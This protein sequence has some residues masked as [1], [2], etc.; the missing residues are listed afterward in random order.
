MLWFV[1]SF[2]SILFAF[3]G[4][5]Y[6]P[7]AKSPKRKFIFRVLLVLTLSYIT[8]LGGNIAEAPDHDAYLWHFNDYAQNGLSSVLDSFR[9]SIFDV[10]GEGFEPLFALLNVLGSKI[11]LSAVG[12]CLMVAIITNA[13]FVSVIFRFRLP[14]LSVILFLVSIDYFQEVNIV[15]QMLAVSICIFSLKYFEEKKWILF[16]VLVIAASFI[17]TSASIMLFLLIFVPLLSEKRR[18]A[19]L[20]L[21]FFLWV[22]SLMVSFGLIPINIGI[23]SAFSYYEQYMNG[24]REGAVFDIIYNFVVIAFLFFAFTEKKKNDLT[25]YAILFILGCVLRNFA[26]QYYWFYRVSFYFSFVYCCFVP[27]FF[28]K[29]GRLNSHG[30]KTQISLPLVFIALYYCLILVRGY[31]LHEPSNTLGTVMYSISEII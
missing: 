28:L 11:G 30:S 18:D 22:F 3:L 29:H 7:M 21:L 31:I 13:L 26:V 5:D 9:Q 10:R 12:F 6:G 15:R 1:V 14:Y 19:L 8:G 25:I 20:L 23:L 16:G 24:L 17:H 27:D 4:D 2:L